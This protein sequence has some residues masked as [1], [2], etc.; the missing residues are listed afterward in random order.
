MLSEGFVVT[1]VKYKYEA[2]QVLLLS[3]FLSMLFSIALQLALL[4]ISFVINY[5]GICN[6]LPLIL[7]Q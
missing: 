2:V 4:I 1:N 5:E 7:M 6:Y 3:I